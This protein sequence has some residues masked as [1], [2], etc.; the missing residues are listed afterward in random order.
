MD[1]VILNLSSKNSL[2]IP[3]EFL[4]KARI[5]CE[6]LCYMEEDRIVIKAVGD[7]EKKEKTK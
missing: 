7:C 4:S 1:K 2:V 3:K 6:C 5:E